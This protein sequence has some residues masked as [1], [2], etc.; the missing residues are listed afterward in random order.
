MQCKAAVAEH[1]ILHKLI[2]TSIARA[3]TFRHKIY[4]ITWLHCSGS[5]TSIRISF[6][7]S[8]H[9]ECLLDNFES[10]SIFLLLLLLLFPSCHW[11]GLT[12]AAFSTFQWILERDMSHKLAIT[13]IC[14]S[15]RKLGQWSRLHMLMSRWVGVQYHHRFTFS[16]SLSSI[17]WTTI[18]QSIWT[19][20]YI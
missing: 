13:G 18:F 8:V 9:A 7:F 15:M 3:H 17:L 2:S 6:Q 19:Y 1:S 12:P 4:S 20:T 10:W 14:K 5:L 11:K 16:S